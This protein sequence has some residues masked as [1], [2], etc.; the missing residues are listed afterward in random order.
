MNIA[1]KL[2]SDLASIASLKDLKKEE[3]EIESPKDPKFGDYSTNIA[4]KLSEKGKNPTDLAGEIAK[5][6][7]KKSL[8]YV[9]KIEIIKPGFINFHLSNK[10]LITQLKELINT[11]EKIVRTGQ[12][13]LIEFTDANPFKEMHIG[14]LYSNIVGESIA[15][16]LESRGDE[17]KRVSYQGDIGL[18]VA[19]A[20][21]GMKNKL[22]E[23]KKSLEELEKESLDARMKF[24]GESYALG[25]KKFEEDLE[26]KEEIIEFNKKLYGKD[27][28]VMGLYDKGRAW[29]LEKFEAIYARLGTKFNK[30]YFES[31][32]ADEGVEIVKK[33]L[34]SGVFEESEGA[35]IFDGE[36]YGLHKRVFVNS[37]G[38]PTYEAKELALAVKKAR[39]FKFDLSIIVT[40]KEVADYFK[41]VLKVFSLMSPELANKTL[42]IGHGFIKLPEG[43]MSSRTGNILT[44]EWL[45]DETVDRVKKEFP[46]MDL[47]TSEKVGVG[48]VKYSLLKSEIG[49]DVVFNISES[50]S[51]EGN[52][53]PYLQYTFVRCQSVL[54]KVASNFEEFKAGELSREEER[55]LKKIVKFNDS[56][57]FTDDFSQ[58]RLCTYLYELASDFNLFYQ[59]CPILGSVN[60]NF[61]LSLTKATSKILSRGLY[62]LGIDTPQKM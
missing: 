3:I 46:D 23:S 28:E 22:Q 4:L 17:V 55:L 15:R 13:V 25:A 31:E 61:R 48:A 43:K 26:A 42:H 30:L 10:I 14:H 34:G 35:I 12:T 39:D 38:L 56:N 32:V 16:I 37:L 51:L 44:A 53:G 57:F 36:K 18:H 21:F 9:E 29:S 6:L 5:E 40:A 7:E 49:K 8:D 59:K 52:S 24:L 58:H 11:P 50:I 60:E 62:L 45:L 1:D 41:V 19:K 2:Q 47:E 27:P 33:H 20:I 54:R